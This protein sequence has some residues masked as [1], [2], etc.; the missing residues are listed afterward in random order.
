[1]R[2]MCEDFG[3]AVFAQQMP[4]IFK[5][6]V[7]LL[8]KK[9]FCQGGDADNEDF[10][11]EEEEGENP[12]D[13]EDDSEE[14]EGDDGIDHDEII[15]GNTTDLI[16]WLAKCLGNEFIPVFNN[17][18]PHLVVYTSEKHPK[19]DRNMAMGSIAE[20]M[21]NSPGCIA[22]YFNDFLQLIEANSHTD[23]SKIN[24]N[25]AYAVGVLA[26]HAPL[27]FQPHLQSSMT[28]LQRLH[29]NSSQPEAQDNIVAASCR[30]VQYQYMPL[31]AD[32]RPADYS[33]MVESIF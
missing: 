6:I 21:A 17:I 10:K 12:E 30:I 5:Y 1:M 22:T 29:A 15:L 24:R 31:P 33:Q 25:L 23:D 28:L 20:V 18:A 3:P 19:S 26:Q 7:Q 14:E 4:N 13:E 16:I 9:T 27:L 8:Q 11:D 2:E 32:Q